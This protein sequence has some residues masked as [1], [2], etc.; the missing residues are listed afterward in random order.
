MA[1]EASEKWLWLMRRGHFS[2]RHFF[3]VF[4]NI[5]EKYKTNDGEHAKSIRPNMAPA[6]T[7]FII[8]RERR[9]YI[10]LK[11]MLENAFL[12]RPKGGQSILPLRAALRFS[13]FG[14][15]GPKVTPAML[16]MRKCASRPPCR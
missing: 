12:G 3:E 1:P 9:F 5:T 2:R 4:W 7:A 6:Y 15:V 13:L 16:D 10:P 14:K 8:L 11:S